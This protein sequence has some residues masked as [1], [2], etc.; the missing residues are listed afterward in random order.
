[1]ATR[2]LFH[3][4]GSQTTDPGG[5][6]L[7]KKSE[8]VNC[9][10]ACTHRLPK[11]MTSLPPSREIPHAAFHLSICKEWPHHSDHCAHLAAA[12]VGTLPLACRTAD[13]Y[14]PV[15]GRS[16]KT[17]RILNSPCPITVRPMCGPGSLHRVTLD[18][19]TR[20]TECTRQITDSKSSRVAVHRWLWLPI[21]AALFSQR[22]VD[23]ET[24]VSLQQHNVSGGH[25]SVCSHGAPL[26]K[27]GAGM[28]TAGQST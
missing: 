5:P 10:V 24:A 19:L 22:A 4:S 6:Q 7:Q 27:G 18:L 9:A 17:D 25:F 14:L 1:V 28:G 11:V 8:P 2:R 20:L 16:C 26:Y 15:G 3:L 12:I 21:Y 23:R 13:V